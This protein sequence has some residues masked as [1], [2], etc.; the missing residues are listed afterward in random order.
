MAVV[1]DT[2]VLDRGTAG[3]WPGRLITFAAWVVGAYLATMLA[4]VLVPTLVL[5]WSPLVVVSGS[6]EPSIRAGDVVLIE[7][8]DHLVGPGTVVAFD[9][10][11]GFVVH[12]VVDV[13]RD[14]SYTT[15]GDANRQPDSTPVSSEQIAGQ[16]RL[17]VPYIGLARVVGW[18]WW[19][20]VGLL[21]AVSIPLWRRG[22]GVTTA[23]AIGLLVVAGLGAG[24]AFLSAT[25]ATA[26]SSIGTLTVDSPTN[27]TARCG[28]P[29]GIGD[30]GVEL[31]WI[32]SSTSEATGYRVLYDAPGGGANF[33]ELVVV[34]PTTTTYTHDLL[35][36]LLGLGTHTYAVQTLVGSWSSSSSN[37]DAIGVTS[38][39]GVFICT[40]Q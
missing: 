21:I 1:G 10:G 35:V 25:T 4:W 2:A 15:Q 34:G 40:E 6:M 11:N 8:V 14:G 23:I 38:L 3:V 28:P 37:T 31:S 30:F 17:L 32:A 16:G 26:S 39:L 13:D 36:S 20:A 7:E 19:V 33:N 24:A 9:D 27:L 18:V 12:R 29:L 22:T 5:G